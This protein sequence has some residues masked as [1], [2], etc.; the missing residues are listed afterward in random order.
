MA[1]SVHPSHS[2]PA[3]AIPPPYS[4]GFSWFSQQFLA[5]PSAT[6]TGLDVGALATRRYADVAKV[7]ARTVGT[8]TA[9]TAI[10]VHGEHGQSTEFRVSASP[11]TSVDT[12]CFTAAE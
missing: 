8:H 3:T 7:H 12:L 6:K 2:A 9:V 11:T 1:P 10:V 4:P 5:A